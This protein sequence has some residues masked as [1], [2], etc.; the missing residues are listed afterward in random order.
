MR[1]G[2][3]IAP[4]R[5][6]PFRHQFLARAISLTGSSLAPV[7]VAFGVLQATGSAGDLGWV[8]AAYSVPMLILM[9]VGG[10]WADRLPRHHVMIAADLTRC[11]TQVAFGLLLV[12]GHAS[13][14]A[15]VA[16]QALNGA[17][18]AFAHPTT[19]GLTAATAPPESLQQA[20]ALLAVTSDLTGIAGPLI[21]G[22]LTV[23]IGAG[24]ALIIDGASFL[25]S[26]LLLSRLHLPPVVRPERRFLT[27]VRDGFREVMRRDWL[28]SSIAYFAVFN[29]VFTLFLVLGPVRLAGV[30]N[31]ALSWGAIMAALSVGTLCGNALALR[32]MPRY[33]LRWPRL[34]ELLLL[35]MIVALATAAPVWIM[36]AAALVMGVIMTFPD[37]LWFT[38][39]QQEIPEEA[40]SRVSSF[41]YLGSF[42]LRPLA[43]VLAAGL[44]AVG[45]SGSLWVIGAVFAVVTLATLAL[46]GTRNLERRPAMEP[47]PE[48]A[49]ATAP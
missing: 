39:L 34:A 27:E 15:M 14:W 2:Q 23:T 4:L 30:P 49:P 48:P 31:G 38:A 25:G 9:L 12:T 22:T 21:A 3:M 33:L 32:I 37:A 29:L 8:M 46:P 28:W 41:D 35:P 6:A 20:N 45:A 19:L 1:L 10:V 5:H 24:W 47:T 7:A 40:I 36:V 42:A 16:L 13:L 43:Y 44:V 17:A 18:Q 11:V 26:A